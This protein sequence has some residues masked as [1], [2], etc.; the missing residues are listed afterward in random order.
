MYSTSLLKA[1]E[2]VID[3]VA[4]ID[5]NIERRTRGQFAKLVVFVDLGKPLISKIR[6]YGRLQRIEYE[7]LPLICFDCGRYGHNRKTCPFKSV[8]DDT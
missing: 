8:N 5:Q 2:G 3:L 1:I 7:S 4:K 6:I